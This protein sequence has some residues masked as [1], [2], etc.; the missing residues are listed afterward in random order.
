MSRGVVGEDGGGKIVIFSVVTVS[1]PIS[2]RIICFV[3]LLRSVEEWGGFPDI[4]PKFGFEV[5][6]INLIYGDMG[7][8]GKIPI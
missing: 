1:I 7:T 2:P 5:R 8:S 6:K 4:L 3:F